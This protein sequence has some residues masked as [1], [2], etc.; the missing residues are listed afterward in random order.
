[1]ARLSRKAGMFN[2]GAPHARGRRTPVV[3]EG[4]EEIIPCDRVVVAFGF[5]P[6][7]Q[8]WFADLGIW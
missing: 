3:I 7:P 8:P 6:N 1:M 4:S 2:G 5:R